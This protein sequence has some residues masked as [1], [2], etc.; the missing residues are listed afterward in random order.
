MLQ[1]GKSKYLICILKE[2]DQIKIIDLVPY[3]EQLS[4]LHWDYIFE[5]EDQNKLVSD[6]IPHSFYY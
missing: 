5:I 3:K 6:A 1:N 4:G 2:W